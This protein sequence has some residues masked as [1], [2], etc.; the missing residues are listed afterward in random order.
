MGDQNPRPL[1]RH[2]TS[3]I[4]RMSCNWRICSAGGL[5]CAAAVPRR[6]ARPC[7]LAV[8]V[9]VCLLA[10]GP[11]QVASGQGSLEGQKARAQQLRGA[12]AAQNAQ[13]SATRGSLAQA[14]QRLASLVARVRAREARLAGAQ[15]RLIDARIHLTKLQRREELSKRTLAENLRAQYESGQ[16]QLVQ[17][18]LASTRFADL[19]R[20]LDMYK[21]L[22]K[23]NARILDATRSARADVA[24]QT[25]SLQR[26]WTRYGQLARAAVADRQQADKLQ[27]ALLV[28]ERVQLARRNGAAS[29]LAVVRGRIASIERRQAIAARAAAAAPSA[30]S[31]APAAAPSGGGGGGGGGGDAVA[32]VVAAANQ[33]A[34]T[35][36]VWGGG[37]GG[38]SGGYDCSGSV[39][40]ALAAG[41][42]LSSPLDSTGFMSWGQPGPGR[43]ITVYAN[44]GHAF[45]IVDGRR[46]DTSAMSGGG[47]RWTSASRSTAG[48]VARHPPGL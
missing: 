40:Y 30:T 35:P 13:L 11:S 38:A 14:E 44:A 33:I 45:M 4:C 34:S 2:P 15:T 17:V 7:A 21:R 46:F 39:S 1:R 12:V 24:G 28:R 29:R 22:S 47:T 26:L 31:A 5:G 19:Y 20:Q 37:H 27:G 10:A 9:G 48:F 3:R 6:S 16:P 23:D 42:L 41:G 18:V 8:L 43:R 25:H 32:R 36:Y